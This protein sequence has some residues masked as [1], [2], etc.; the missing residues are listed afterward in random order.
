MMISPVEIP[1]H[2]H[3]YQVQRSHCLMGRPVEAHH[4]E[5]KDRVEEG[6]IYWCRQNSR[7]HAV[8]LSA[9]PHTCHSI[10]LPLQFVALSN[11]P[12]LVWNYGSMG[13][14]AGLAGIFFWMHVS[15]LDAQ[16]DELNN[17]AD[18]QFVMESR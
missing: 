4:S 15:K 16:A 14:L 10:Q 12:L 8:H 18:G 9:C 5:H 3:L 17:L 6:Y 1:D 13:V 7:T 2:D 11:D